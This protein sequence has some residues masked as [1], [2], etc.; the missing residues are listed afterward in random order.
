MYFIESVLLENSKDSKLKHNII[1][2][3][4]FFSALLMPFSLKY[5][6]ILGDILYGTN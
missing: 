5:I 4:W 1:F 3:V 6:H 2:H